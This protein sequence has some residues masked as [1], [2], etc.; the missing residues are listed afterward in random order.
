MCATFL[1]S[2]GV[3]VI[4]IYL[5][6]KDVEQFSLLYLFFKACFILLIDPCEAPA[7]PLCTDMMQA[8]FLDLL[9]LVQRLDD[10][11]LLYPEVFLPMP[12]CFL[13]LRSS[14]LGHGRL[15]GLCAFSLSMCSMRNCFFVNTLPFTFRYRF[16]CIWWSIFFDSSY[17]L[18]S[19]HRILIL[20]IQFT[21][22]G[23]QDQAVPFC[24]FMPIC[25]SSH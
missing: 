4:F 3:A 21:F 11:S 8:L 9:L 24:F 5:I 19:W 18:R 2:F 7:R 16:R 6:G 23:I 12:P 15:M 20:L 14:S 17:L 22:S 1:F 25:L 13:A 10:L